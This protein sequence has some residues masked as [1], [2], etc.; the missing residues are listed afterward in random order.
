MGDGGQA[1]AEQ[2]REVGTGVER[3]EADGRCEKEGEKS[4]DTQWKW[5]MAKDSQNQN[6]TGD[7]RLTVTKEKHFSGYICYNSS[8]SG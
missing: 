5:K 1:P 4:E 3:G 2:M 6:M 7:E 8:I